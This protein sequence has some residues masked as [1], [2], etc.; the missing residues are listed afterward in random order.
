MI[1]RKVVDLASKSG[2][3]TYRWPQTSCDV[4]TQAQADTDEVIN[5]I[6]SIITIVVMILCFFSLVSTMSGNVLH[7][8]R[9]I[10]VLR[11]V[12]M[13]KRELTMLYVYEAFVLIFSSSLFGI[14]IGLFVGVTMTAQRALFSNIPIP[15]EFPYY[16]TAVVLLVSVLCAFGSSVFPARAILQ[17]EI[18]NIIKNTI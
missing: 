3:S 6:F 2:L 15:F 7:S 16:N 13:T 14:L 10:G 17:N 18:S 11:A 1:T 5:L 9:E 8:A 12:G 4:F